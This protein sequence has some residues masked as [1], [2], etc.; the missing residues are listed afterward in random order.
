M[1]KLIL[2]VLIATTPLMLIASASQNQITI[3]R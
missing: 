1:K 2:A 3:E